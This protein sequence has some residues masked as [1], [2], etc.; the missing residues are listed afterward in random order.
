MSAQG[1]D[2]ELAKLYRTY[3]SLILCDILEKLGEAP[4]RENKLRLHEA[5][6]KI[7]ETDSISGRPFEYVSEF[8]FTI[9][10]WYAT[11]MGIFIRT[12]GKMPENIAE[13]DLKD[14]WE[15]L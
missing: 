13:M 4:T 9:V 3:W 10:A 15:Y 8:V 11:E 5:H 6:K 1:E 12:S 14:C 7:Y 2:R